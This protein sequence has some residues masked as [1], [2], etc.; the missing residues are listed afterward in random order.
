MVKS[1][2]SLEQEYIAKTPV[3]KAQWQKGQ[4]SMP[5]GVI[6]GAYWSSPYPDYVDR[7]EGCYVWNLDGQK[8]V[9]FGNHHSAMLLGHSHPNVIKAIE[10]ARKSSDTLIKKEAGIFLQ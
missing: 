6:K 8:F 9:D 3:S 2:Q 5:G 1:L 7:A 4:S 10:K